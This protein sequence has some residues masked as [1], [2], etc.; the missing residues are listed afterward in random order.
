M[1]SELIVLGLTVLLQTGQL[2]LYSIL[3]NKQVGVRYSTGPRDEPRVLKGAAGRLQ[4]CINNQFESLILF[5]AAVVIVSLS[6]RATSYT[7]T[8]AWIYLGARVLYL[9]A[10]LFAWTYWRSA[11][12]G[13]GLLSILAMIGTSLL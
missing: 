1:S 6:D 3:A 5:T 11:I 12:W 9:P 4:R 8:W 10:Y 2:G 7:A 13:V